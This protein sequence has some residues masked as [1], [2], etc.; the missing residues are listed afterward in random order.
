MSSS[1]V[2]RWGGLAGMLAGVAWAVSGIV[3]FVLVYPEAGPGP[4]GS[5]SAYLIEA[6]HAV[7]EASMLGVLFG[8]RA[9]QASRSGWLG[10]AGFIAAFLGTALMLV[11]TLLVLIFLDAVGEAVLTGL[12]AGGV[13]TTIVGFVLL[14]IATV[15]AKV[16]PGWYGL[17]LIAHPLL[18]FVM[19]AF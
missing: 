4:L 7:A 16:L 18:F 1:N 19:L 3:Q 17:L 15:R 13:L 9:R 2:I 5:T 12:F 14:G 6:V 10:L 11:A 8:L